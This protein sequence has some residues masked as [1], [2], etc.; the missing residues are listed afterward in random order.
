MTTVAHRALDGRRAVVTGGGRGI[1][2]A[3]ALALAEAGAA[4]AVVARTRDA[5]EAVAAEIA[6]AGGEASAIACDVT[7]PTSVERMA[8]EVARE[9]G[10][11]DLLVNAAGGAETHK[12]IG[13]PDELWHRV[14]ALNLT[15]TYLVTKA[16]APGMVERRWGRIVNIASTNAKTGSRYTAAYTA[17]K[18]GVL[19]LTRVL[20]LEFATDGVTVNAICPGFVDT[21]MTDASIANIVKR[22]G[23]STEKARDALTQTSPQRRLMET[24]EVAALAVFLAGNAAAGITGQAI[25]VDGGAVLW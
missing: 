18:H 24:G 9:P 5:I 25:N 2:R 13:H 19:G 22:T 4:V 8:G 12:L 23:M 10:G 15:S 11:V 7:D 16:F 20:A 14:L 3:I 21:P 1:G 6:A 17:S